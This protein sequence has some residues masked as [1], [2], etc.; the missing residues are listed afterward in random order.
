MRRSRKAQLI[1]EPFKYM[2]VGLFSII[3]LVAGYKM[4]NE[5]RNRACKTEM[6][7]FEIDLMD[8]DKSLRFG[9]KELR[10]YSV[11]CNIDK[12]YFFDLNKKINP[13]IFNNT[14]LIKDTLKSGGNNNVFLVE[15]GEVKRS[16][17]AGTIEIEQPYYLCFM[18]KFDKI[19]FFI[20]STGVS[21]RMD[22]PDAQSECA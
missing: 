18:P 21:V 2:L 10:S 6:A 5:V 7:K 8:I 12:I 9:A 15:E 17:Y 22:K 20:E 13:E 16:F 14:P 3:V 19:S 1:G 4:I 11:P